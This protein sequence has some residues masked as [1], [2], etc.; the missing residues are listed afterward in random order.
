MNRPTT[1]AICL[2]L[3]LLLGVFFLYPK[4]QDLTILQKKIKGKKA[5]L[6][7]KEGY[8][9]DLSDTSEKLKQY[10]V[11]FSKIDSALPLKPSLPSLFNFLQRA[12]SQNG[13]I[14]QEISPTFAPNSE[15]LRETRVTLIMTGSYSSFKSF[16]STLEKSARIIEAESISFAS[17]EEAETF[18]FTL[19]L[20]VY[21]Y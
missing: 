2:F 10:E 3:T 7:S 15:G 11:Q 21:S 17:S 9:L 13:L 19:G 16:L 18:I 20:K 5:E 4:Y 6:H 1:I 12:A 14:L 8:F